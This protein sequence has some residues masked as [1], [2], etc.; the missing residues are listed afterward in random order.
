MN[1]AMGKGT[2]VPI[3]IVDEH[4][5]ILPYVHLAIRKKRLP[6]DTSFDLI[7]FDAHPD[8]SIPRFHPRVYHDPHA[9]YAAL[10]A[11]PSGI[12][13]FILPL[14]YAGHVDRII[15]MKPSWCQQM[16]LG[17]HRLSIGRGQYRLRLRGGHWP[18]YLDVDPPQASQEEVL[19][20]VWDSSILRYIFSNIQ[21]Y[22]DHV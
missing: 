13:E 10:D 5:E 16:P 22:S 3:V 18:Y 6:F 21:I 1:R 8:L 19:S 2:H 12:S 9:L 17:I 20:K 15:W 7:H 11:S 14:V 4:H